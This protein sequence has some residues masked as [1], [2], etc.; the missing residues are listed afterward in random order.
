MVIVDR[1]SK[2]K[3]FHAIAHPYTALMVAQLF[4]DNVYKL[5]GL[6]NSIVSNGDTLF[7]SKF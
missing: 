5:H 2:N 3:H 1:L 6:P 4:L 7:V